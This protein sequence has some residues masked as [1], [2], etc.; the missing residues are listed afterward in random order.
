MGRR[1]K[2]LIGLCWST[3]INIF[4]VSILSFYQYKSHKSGQI[5]HIGPLIFNVFINFG[6]LFYVDLLMLQQLS[7]RQ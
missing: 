2:L 6:P 7:S 4:T 1:T 5:I 3:L